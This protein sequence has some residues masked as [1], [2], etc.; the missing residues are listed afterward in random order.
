M[1]RTTIAA[2]LM[3]ACALALAFS[4]RAWAQTESVTDPPGA[5]AQ[6]Q[7]S[8]GGPM[9]VERVRDGF[10]IAPDFKISK[11]DGSAARLAGVYGGWVIDNSLL[12]GAGGYWLTNGSDVRSLGYGGAVV[13]WLALTDRPVGFGLRGLVGF[14]GAT[15]SETAT[16]LVYQPGSTPPQPQPGVGPGRVGPPFAPVPVPGTASPQTVQFGVNRG[17][18]VAEPEADFLVNFTPRVR[19]NWSAG[20]RLIGAPDSFDSRLRGATASV[21]LELGGSTTSRH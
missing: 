8:I 10:A 7:A 12:I 16:V 6:Q 18:F 3:P 1:T 13:E 9:S 19:L 4:S 15:L 20:Y 21:A 5:N 17:F 11:I 14:G 2:G